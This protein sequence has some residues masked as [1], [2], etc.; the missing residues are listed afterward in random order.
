MASEMRGRLVC[1]TS[2]RYATC[3]RCQRASAP[4][5]SHPIPTSTST[6]LTYFR[7]ARAASAALI[8]RSSSFLRLRGSMCL[9]LLAPEDISSGRKLEER[10]T[11]EIVDDAKADGEAKSMDHS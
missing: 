1:T 3:P 6:G 4:G 5:S 10:D 8:T 11:V 2:S 7:A 9:L